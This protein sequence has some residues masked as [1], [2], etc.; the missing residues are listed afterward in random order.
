[1]SARRTKTS[2]HRPVTSDSS[3]EDFY[4]RA[5]RATRSAPGRYDIDHDSFLGLDAFSGDGI[6]SDNSGVVRWGY[7]LLFLTWTAFVLGIGGV[8]GIWDSIL[9][10]TS[11][12]DDIANGR[13][14][15]P[16]AKLSCF[17]GLLPVTGFV[18][19]LLNWLGLKL[20]RMTSS[21]V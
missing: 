3:S 15:S 6:P 20:F 5:T 9:G 11:I 7:I 18:W 21:K 1:M 17:I 8:L 19:T 2:K 14:Y 10:F 4:G 12:S 16:L 13:R